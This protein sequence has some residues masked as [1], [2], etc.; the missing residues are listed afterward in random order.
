MQ[1]EKEEEPYFLILYYIDEH[2]KLKNKIESL[3]QQEPQTPPI[4]IRRA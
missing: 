1:K 2:E 3:P 4:V